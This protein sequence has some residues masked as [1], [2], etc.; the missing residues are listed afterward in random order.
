MCT[1]R[2]GYPERASLVALSFVAL[3]VV[4]CRSPGAVEQGSIAAIESLLREQQFDW[5]R[6]DIPAFME[7][8]ARSEELRFVSGDQTTIGWQ[9]TLDRYERRYGDREKMG[10][11]EFTLVDVELLAAGVGKV[12]G[13]WQLSF[14]DDST[15]GMFTLILRRRPEGWRIVHDHTS[16]QTGE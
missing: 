9:A 8:Y 1:V 11:L 14:T 12:V 6:G 7:G 4:G 16:V 15:G 5:N 10:S 13:K 3:V 2:S